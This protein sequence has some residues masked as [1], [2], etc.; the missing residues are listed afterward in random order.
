MQKQRKVLNVGLSIIGGFALIGF[1]I[2][3]FLDEK[4]TG[5][6]GNF[7]SVFG[8]LFTLL[9]PVL[10]LAIGEFAGALLFFMPK[11]E[12]KTWDIILRAI[13]AAAFVAF[14]VFAIKE[15][16]EYVD[17]PRM[18]QNAT[19]FKVL[20]ITLVVL[21]DI[22]IILFVKLGMKHIDAKK[23]IPSVIVVFVI[24]ASWV[25]VSEVIK[26][27]ASRPR[28]R[29]VYSEPY[30]EF[31]N[32]YQFQ[33]FLCLKDGYKECKSFVSGHTFIAACSISSI[34]LML[35]LKKENSGIKMTI[36]GLAVGGVFSF[37]TAFSRIVAYAHFMSDVMGAIVASCAAQAIILNVAPLIHKKHTK[38]E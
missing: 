2:G 10:A 33:P 30:F 26:H 19:T 3:T 24:I 17:F 29:V 28:P 18:A 23:I 27:L 31:R 4:I 25:F 20:S 12:N 7:D 1:I 22:G 21:I 32:W 5:S 9:A 11:I 16:K 36:I 37:V 14:S 34:P 38:S 35:S 8:I 6:L 15:G 13:G